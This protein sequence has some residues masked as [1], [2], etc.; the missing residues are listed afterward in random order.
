[1]TDV[2]AEGVIYNSEPGKPV[3]ARPTQSR[4]MAEVLLLSSGSSAALTAPAVRVLAP[5]GGVASTKDFPIGRLLFSGTGADDSTFDYQVILWVAATYSGQ[6]SNVYVPQVIARGTVTLGTTVAPDGFGGGRMADVV[7]ET[8]GLP[9]VLPVSP[10]NN[11]VGCLDL[12]LRNASIIQVQTKLV[13]ATAASVSIVLGDGAVIT[14]QTFD[15][16]TIT[17]PEAVKVE[18]SDGDQI[19]PSTTGDVE[20]VSGANLTVSF[21][22]ISSN[23]GTVELLAA[24]VGKVARV[25]SLCV[26][27]AAQGQL[28]FIDSDETPLSG[29]MAGTTFDLS[30]DTPLL[31]LVQASTGKGISIVVNQAVAGIATVSQE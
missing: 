5:V 27:L 4:R 16:G 2:L 8:L 13:D 29:V 18:N 25:H 26:T 3:A 24:S 11:L 30:R 12:P 17:V 20:A 15:I 6:T 1:M 28:Q 9:G 21:P 19:D 7:T 14:N 23:A 22:L 31:P 10:S